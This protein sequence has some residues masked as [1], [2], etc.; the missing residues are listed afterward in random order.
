MRLKVLIFFLLI[1][2]V[3]FFACDRSTEKRKIKL[4]DESVSTVSGRQLTTTIHLEPNEQ[5]SIAVMFFQN[6]TGDNNLQWLQKG[7]TEMLI[8]ALSQSRSLSV[9]S[10]ERLFEIFERLGKTLPTGKIDMDM[11]VIMAEEANV[12]AIL[13]GEI[14]KNGDSLKIYVR[15]HEPGQGLILKETSVEGPGLENIFT[16]VDNLSRKIKSDL[17]IAFE[18]TD[19]SRGIAELTTNSLDAWKQYSAGVDLTNRF[20]IDEA[21]PHFEKAIALDS[22]FAA[23]YIKLCPLYLRLDKR[24]QAHKL[25]QKLQMIKEKATPQERYQVD[26]L[27]ARFNNDAKAFIT[28]IKEWLKKYPDDRDANYTLAELYAE[29]HNVEPAIKYFN[30]VLEIDPKYK[31]AYNRLGYAY[32]EMGDFS[33]AIST[34]NKYKELAVDEHNPYDSMGDVY[35]WFGDFKNAVKHYKKALKLNENFAASWANLAGVYFERGDYKKALKTYKKYLKKTHDDFTGSAAYSRIAATYLRIGD[36]DKAVTNYKKSLNT[37]FRNFLALECLSDI[38]FEMGDS[39][40]AQELFIQIYDKLKDR[41]QSDI[42]KI[43]SIN[44]LVHFSFWSGVNLN[45][46]IDILKN[47]LDKFENQASE[48]EVDNITL[49]NLR[50]SLT[51]LY[52]KN[53]QG[54]KIADLWQGQ[55]IIPEELWKILKGVRN[56]NYSD[57]WRGFEVLNGYYYNNFDL[58][59]S[60]YEKLIVNAREYEI[61]A[62]EMMFRLFL[63]DLYHQTGNM[64]QANQQRTLAGIPAEEKWMVIG[65]FDNKDGFRKKFAPEKRVDLSETYNGKSGK[66]SWQ[67][68]N[69]G[70]N[71]GFVNFREIY[72]RYKW[73]VSYGLINVI[74]QEEKEVQFRFGTDDGSKVWLNGY[75]VWKFNQPTP[76]IFDRHKVNVTLKKGVNRVKV[77]VYNTIGD[78]GFFFRIT[79]EEGNGVPNILFVSADTNV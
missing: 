57:S 4:S 50:N 13:T 17:Q 45:E 76:A 38:Y 63:A 65:P 78:W 23:A 43:E 16:M 20:R 72:K 25:F 8:R 24:E 18:K 75:E 49:N 64:Q 58:G 69:D 61:K 11:A 51:I 39:T 7:L 60:F 31:I 15:L 67:H 66:V 48:I 9:L 74:S 46:T 6:L 10:T 36:K 56:F 77:K 3:N 40:I 14:T 32:A 62:L 53:K 73:S 27:E 21:M 42:M 26:I 55:E 5:L 41:L 68:A 28:A 1:L 12:E 34:L 47:A 59:V 19:P 22:T 35:R 79:D 54:D 52:L 30:K 29:W 2:I 70:V 71:D 37:N 44:H 33:K